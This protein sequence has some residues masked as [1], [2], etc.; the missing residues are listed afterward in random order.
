MLIGERVT[1]RA[2]TKADAELLLSW[3]NDPAFWGIYYNVWPTLIEAVEERIQ[4]WQSG[5][6]ELYMIVDRE[7]GEPM[8]MGGFNSPHA[9]SYRTAFPDVEVWYGVA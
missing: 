1:L 5:E 7:T 8:G 4:T 9:A 6:G 2:T 3:Y